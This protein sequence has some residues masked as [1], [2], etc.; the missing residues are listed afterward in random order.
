MRLYRREII[1]CLFLVAATLSV[2]WQVHNHDFVNYDDNTYVTENIQVQRG[3]DPT[4][5]LW[6]FTT[7]YAN[8]WHP[9]T[10]L[11]HMLDCQLFGLTPGMHHLSNLIL[12][13]INTILLF[14]V[15]SAM[16]GSLWRSAVVAALFALHPLHVESVAWVS[17][18]KDLVS[19]LFWFLTMG[20]YLWYVRRPG[21]PRYLPVLLFFVMGLMAKPML[22]TLPFVLL[23]LDYW[24]LNRIR[25][26]EPDTSDSQ[27]GTP[28][29]VLLLE[30]LPL[31]ALTAVFCIVAFLA[32]QQGGAT[33]S[34]DTYPLGVRIS[35]AL[36]S[37]ALYIGKMFWPQGL[38]V[39]YPHPRELQSWQA[40]GSGILL[41]FLTVLSLREARRRP[42]LVVGWLWFIG[43]MVPVIGLVQV[44][45]HAM[46]DRY[47]YVPL[48]GLFIA[49]VWGLSDIASTWHHRRAILTLSAGVVLAS[50]MAVSWFQ[51]RHWQ[52]SITLFS[53]TLAVTSNNLKAH[54]NLGTAQLALGNPEEA[55]HHFSAAVQINP[56]SAITRYNLGLALL[57]QERFTEAALQYLEALRIKPDFQRAHRDLGETLFA[58]KRYDEAIVHLARA[59]KID[60][61][62]VIAHNKLGD[63]LLLRRRFDEAV[64]H[65]AAALRLR[66][67]YSA[68]YNMGNALLNKG[69]LDGAITSFAESLRLNPSNVM[70]HN[71][72]GNALSRQGNLKEAVLHY[73]EALRIKPDF[74]AAR[75][76]LT[77]ALKQMGRFD[78]TTLKA[79]SP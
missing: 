1:I 15:F 60:P 5:V 4:T 3:L 49:L 32:Q 79:P 38:A 68:H 41:T 24:P 46:A 26:G 51:V 77:I 55:A 28:M 56:G 73:R 34:L 29:S 30:K 21:L 40:I 76:N 20:S 37:Y 13:I 17:E 75:A 18:R 58:Q 61:G 54:N 6:A 70:A 11:S 44:G 22:V 42:S 74:G 65:F 63:L 25:F 7:T 64:L 23:L 53:H 59:V 45:S 16:T 31:F 14:L 62:D 69:D 67:D 48:I 33:G 2:F 66:P 71:N 9:L 35:N 52:N 57:R 10:W 47:T 39:Y 78:G 8:F 36:V 27:P 72:M 50:L 43:T 19:T 12:H